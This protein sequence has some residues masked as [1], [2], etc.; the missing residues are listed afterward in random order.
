MRIGASLFRGGFFI[1]AGRASC[2]AFLLFAGV[3]S[4]PFG[5]R[6]QAAQ[7]DAGSE[8]CSSGRG[9]TLCGRDLRFSPSEGLPA[10][11]SQSL[12]SGPNFVDAPARGGLDFAGAA[13]LLPFFRTQRKRAFADGMTFAARMTFARRGPDPSYKLLSK[14]GGQN[15][16]PVSNGASDRAPADF[17][18]VW[19]PST[20]STLGAATPD[21]P[22]QQF[23]WL[24]PDGNPWK[25]PLPLTAWGQ[26]KMKSNRPTGSETTAIDSNDPDFQCFPSGVPRIY[27]FLYPMEIIHTPGRVLQLFQYGHSLRQIF[28]DGRSQPQDAEPTWMRDSI[29]HWEA[30]TLGVDTTD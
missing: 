4:V 16:S 28:T 7:R 6:G 10:T 24:G 21:N 23:V 3:V 1:R 20:G 2:A 15:A 8:R 9:G 13:K 29:G 25:G 18:G 17:A 5:L 11:V 22:G 30:D 26:E 19:Y 12:G 14:A 27:L